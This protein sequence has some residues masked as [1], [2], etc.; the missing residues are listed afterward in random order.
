MVSSGVSRY[1]LDHHTAETRTEEAVL[2]TMEKYIEAGFKFVDMYFH[3]SLSVA[4]AEPER[5]NGVVVAG[6][7]GVEGL[8]GGTGTVSVESEAMDVDDI[9][10]EN[11]VERSATPHNSK[12]RDL[13]LHCSNEDYE[14]RQRS[15]PQGQ[16]QT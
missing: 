9:A 10:G 13:F 1:L 14:C 8:P 16:G 11:T 4:A 15:P 6:E 5:R 7:A 2:G 3:R 12:S